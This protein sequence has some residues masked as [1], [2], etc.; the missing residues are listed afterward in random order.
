M[1]AQA[2]C[3]VPC[4][5][6]R[7]I[8][9][10]FDLER[11]SEPRCP[12]CGRAFDRH[13]AGTFIG[14]GHT[15]VSR[16]L[17]QAPGW[18]MFALASLVVLSILASGF[19]PGPGLGLQLSALLAGVVLGFVYIGRVI[20]GVTGHLTL[21]RCRAGAVPIAFHRWIVPPVAVALAVLLVESDVTRKVAFALDRSAL[22]S[23][24]KGAPVQPSAWTPVRAWSG[25]VERGAVWS[26][27]DVWAFEPA[28]ALGKLKDPLAPGPLAD[29]AW[30]ATLRRRV[31]ETKV[32][33]TIDLRLAR[34]AVFPISGTGYDRMLSAAWAYAPNAPDVFGLKGSVFLR[35][36]GDWYASWSWINPLEDQP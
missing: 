20:F 12:E 5:A 13:D 8:D 27:V 1:K 35:Y 7:C 17:A 16:R 25:S 29:G 34:L 9:C 33:G 26:D 21:I 22:Q 23:I 3:V 2:T 14:P 15:R 19:G 24:A 6:M 30:Q 31:G 11:I 28:S 10:D 32:D 4:S 18:P 36:S